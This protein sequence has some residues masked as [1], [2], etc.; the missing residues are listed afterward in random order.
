MSLLTKK[1]KR[2]FEY[3]GKD[4]Y[5]GGRLRSFCEFCGVDIK[6]SQENVCR[7]CRNSYCS[8]HKNAVEH[9]C[10]RRDEDPFMTW[11]GKAKYRS[12]YA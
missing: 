3:R 7:F 8:E 5:E 9:K 10:K 12:K 11:G 4:G 1:I 2:L 6:P